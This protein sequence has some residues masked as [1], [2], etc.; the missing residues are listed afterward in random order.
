MEGVNAAEALFDR[1]RPAVEQQGV[2]FDSVE[3][4]ELLIGA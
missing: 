1:L 4:L 3:N 2:S